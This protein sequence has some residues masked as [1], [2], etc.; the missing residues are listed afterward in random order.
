MKLI[1]IV[2][3][4]SVILSLTV[5]ECRRKTNILYELNCNGKKKM[6]VL[7]ESELPKELKNCEIIYKSNER[8]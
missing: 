2:G 4:F 6:I 3:I 5:I 7:R 1:H 8:N